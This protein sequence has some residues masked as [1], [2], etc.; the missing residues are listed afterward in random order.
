[1]RPIQ[2]VRKGA[3]DM[4]QTLKTTKTQFVKNVPK[5]LA[6]HITLFAYLSPIFPPHQWCKGM[7]AAPCMYI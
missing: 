7:S 1:M 6:R 2:K 4:A 3:A 5:K